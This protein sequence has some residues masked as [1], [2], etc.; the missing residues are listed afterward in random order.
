VADKAFWSFIGFG[1][2][3]ILLAF[4][5]GIYVFLKKGI[6]GSGPL[7]GMFGLLLFFLGASLAMML[8]SLLLIRM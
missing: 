2:V 8:G 7:S 4:W 6:M 5:G 1:V 3:T